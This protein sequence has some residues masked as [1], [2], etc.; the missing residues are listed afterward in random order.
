MIWGAKVSNKENMSVMLD[1]QLGKLE[2]VPG[3]IPGAAR[4]SE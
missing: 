4:F 3:S 1:L 2:K